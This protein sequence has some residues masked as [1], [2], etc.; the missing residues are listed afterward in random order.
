MPK[1][2]WEGCIE[3]HSSYGFST[4]LLLAL[5]CRVF[6]S[7]YVLAPLWLLCSSDSSFSKIKGQTSGV[8]NGSS[9]EI[10]SEEQLDGE[11]DY[12]RVIN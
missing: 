10:V 7:F 12:V 2:L 1:T 8:N 9:G 5:S 3:S 6:F 4:L 11:L